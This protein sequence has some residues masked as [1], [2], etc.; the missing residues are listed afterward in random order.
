[1]VLNGSG[2]SVKGLKAR[3][4]YCLMPF[5]ILARPYSLSVDI[6]LH[7]TPPI[8]RQSTPAFRWKGY[9]LFSYKVRHFAK[10]TN[11]FIGLT[12]RHKGY[13]LFRAKVHH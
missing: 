8:P 1:M 3:L 7:S 13:H 6:P 2:N 10:G 11:A 4:S 5:G 12:F 9:Q